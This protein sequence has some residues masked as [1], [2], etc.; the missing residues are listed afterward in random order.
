MGVNTPPVIVSL[1]RRP[2]KG[3]S[4]FVGGRASLRS[5]CARPRPLT[6]CE[7]DGVFPAVASLPC[8]L[9]PSDISPVNGGNLA[10]QGSTP[11]YSP[12]CFAKR[13]GFPPARE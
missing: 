5:R 4:L 11:L 7:G 2:R 13:G 6:L 10:L 3:A 9:C 12:F 1:A 8:P